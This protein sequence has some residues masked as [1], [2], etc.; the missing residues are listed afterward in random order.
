VFH[1]GLDL[2]AAHHHEARRAEH[3]PIECGEVYVVKPFHQR[4]P[5]TIAAVGLIVIALG[6]VAA[7]NAKSLPIIGGGTTYTANVRESTGLVSGDSV[8]IAGVRV[9]QVEDVELAGDHVQVSFRVKDAFVGNKS[10]AAIKIQTLLGSK[11]LAVYSRGSEP[12]EPS[13]P[14]PENRAQ[15]VYYDVQAAFQGLSKHVQKIDTKQLEQSF[16]V[17]NHT[18]ENTPKDVRSALHGLSRLSKTI[19]SR[20]KELSKLLANTAQV[21]HTLAARDQQ[22]TKLLGDGSLLLSELQARKQA[23]DKLLT[24]TI[25]LAHQVDGLVDDNQAQLKPV[26]DKLNQFTTML[27]KNQGSLDAGIRKLAPFVRVFN[28]TIGNGHW[29]DSYVCGLLPPSTGPINPTG[30]DLGG[31]SK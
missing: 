12:H 6:I 1:A 29:F 30:C 22:I 2:G 8:R 13:V 14:L 26:L 18:F 28:N 20:D 19:A 16:E 4:N 25:R 17:L 3:T 5:I 23:I 15:S 10:N 24:G 27:R 31:G 7:L 11:Y 9:G 21:S